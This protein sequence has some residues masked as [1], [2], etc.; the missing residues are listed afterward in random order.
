MRL[1][2]LDL[3]TYLTTGMSSSGCYLGYIDEEG[4]W[5]SV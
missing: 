5:T 2:G 1:A 4:E 3:G